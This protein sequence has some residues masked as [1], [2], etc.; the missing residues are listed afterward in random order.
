M[1]PPDRHSQCMFNTDDTIVAIS[2]AAGSAARAIVRLSG[3]QAFELA[4]SVFAP[5]AERLS[6]LGGFRT[7]EGLVA[8]GP[9]QIE[10]PGRAYVFRAPRSFTRQDVVEL[11]IP[12]SAVLAGAL[13]DVLITLDDREGEKVVFSA[14][15]FFS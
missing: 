5:L 15:A 10:L 11:H 8:I 13:A 3:P 9:R 1:T 12:G 2:T 4:G 7:A 6:D 14:R